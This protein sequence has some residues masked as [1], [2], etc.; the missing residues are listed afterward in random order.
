MEEYYIIQSWHY[1]NYNLQTCWSGNGCQSGKSTTSSCNA[2]TKAHACSGSA[3]KFTIA[4][5]YR[6]HR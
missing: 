3:G 5:T 6:C 4:D 2:S 1:V